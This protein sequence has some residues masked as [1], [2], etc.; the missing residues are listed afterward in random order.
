MT[1]ESRSTFMDGCHRYGITPGLVIQ[2]LGMLV[3]FAYFTGQLKATEDQ[4]ADRMTRV[5]RVLD[6][7]VL[8]MIK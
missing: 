4:V 1:K 8:K 6:G 5:E 7:L 2:L 3:M